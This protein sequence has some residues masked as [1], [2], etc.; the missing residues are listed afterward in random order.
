E[1]NL[2]R[3]GFTCITL[4]EAATAG[5]LVDPEKVRY[6]S[7]FVRSSEAAKMELVCKEEEVDKAIGIIEKY[8]RRSQWGDGII[9]VSPID[10][11]IDIRTTEEETNSLKTK[12]GR[13]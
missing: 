3:A 4:V 6:S 2:E 7:Q 1:T 11:V 8:G 9:I 10:R 12:N 5:A 13:R